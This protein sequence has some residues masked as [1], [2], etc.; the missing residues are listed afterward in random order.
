[1]L[2]ELRSVSVPQLGLRQLGDRLRLAFVGGLTPYRAALGVV[3]LLTLAFYMWT[4]ASTTAFDFGSHNNDLYN[5]LTSGFVHGHLYL[6]V[7]PP[8]GLLHLKNP[9]DPAQNA[10]YQDQ[11]NF[12]ALYHG[13]LYSAWGPTPVV[14]LF[15]PFRIT[16][17]RMSQSFAVALFGFVGLL[18]AVALLHLL[19]RRF[20]P[21]T[22]NWLLLA[23]SA[24]LALSNVVPFLLRRPVQYEVAISSGYC[25]AMAAL[26]LIAKALTTSRRRWP[27][28]SGAS[29]CLGLSVGGRI[30]LAPLCL[31]VI[32]AALYLIR[33]RDEPYRILVPLLAPL[34][35]C[36][37][38]LAAYNAAR[39]GSITQFGSSYQIAT[40]NTNTRAAGQ[41]S[42]LPPGLFSY[43]LIPPRLALTFPHVFLA[44]AAQYPFPFPHGYQGSPSDPYVEPAG[45]LLPT[46]PITLLLLLLPT[47]WRRSPPGQRRVWL[48]ASGLAA[49][50]LVIVADL[51]YALWG[52]TQRYEVDYVTLFLL[53]A[54]LVWAALFARLDGRRRARRAVAAAGLALTAIGALVG[55]ATSIT[56]YYDALSLEHPKVFNTLEDITSPFATV[57]T[58]L[59]GSPAIARVYGPLPVNLPPQGYGSTSEKGA[60]TYLGSEGAV[61]VVI[62]S[63]SAQNK[64]LSAV[65]QAGS[66]APRKTHWAIR[67]QSPGRAATVVSV[68]GALVRMPV[69]LHWGLNRIKLALASPQ[70]SSP[71]QLYLGALFLE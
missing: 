50:G 35:V 36:A 3:L 56:G 38:L 39:F 41:L 46:A 24:G 65:A 61:T 51:S 29:L 57:A 11:V 8:P 44:S 40:V 52:T 17:L 21:R 19:V 62:D 26:L 68:T 9:F 71:Q 31:V 66:G 64:V 63:P 22:P 25:F 43:L 18:C 55:A 33:R 34:A 1:M 14:T 49:L 54:F 15:L 12:A 4:A 2:R 59:G 53:P 45:G 69:H 70:P 42:Y 10:P 60:G 7:K 6:A 48:V 28:L 47:L 58:M 20:V 16:G 23:A 13:H 32:P 37:V 30:S 5:E 67:V 27:L